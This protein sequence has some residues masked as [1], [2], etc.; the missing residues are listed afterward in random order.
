[1]EWFSEEFNCIAF[2][3]DGK[4]LAC[5]SKDKIIELWDANKQ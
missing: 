5:Y 1:M 3:L 4:Y 2:S